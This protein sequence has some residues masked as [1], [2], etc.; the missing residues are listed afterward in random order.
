[1]LLLTCGFVIR[2]IA[3]TST[4]A[5]AQSSTTPLIVRTSKTSEP[6]RA[7]APETPAPIV[8]PPGTAMYVAKRGES[9]ISV[10]RQFISKTSYLTTSEL[11]EAIRKSNGD[12]QGT[13]L[14]AG[15]QLII[16]GILDAPIVE[17]AVA[18]PKDFE[19]R[20]VY[21]TGVMAGSDRGLKII[22]RWREV[23]GNA[24]VF[25]VKDSDGTINIP[26]EHPLL[27]KHQVYIRDLPKFVHFLH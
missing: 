20:A 9:V 3:F 23:G 19:V 7:T 22:R 5:A 13:F 10:A 24:V 18:V 8:A 11:A 15:Q 27:G 6:V 21:L 17:K 14:K 4:T 25:D 12:F 2:Q 1:M 26:F 16:P